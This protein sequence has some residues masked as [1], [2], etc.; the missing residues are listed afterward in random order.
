MLNKSGGTM[1]N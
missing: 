1:A